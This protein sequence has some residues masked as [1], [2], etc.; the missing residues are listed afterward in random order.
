V[1]HKGSARVSLSTGNGNEL[2]CFPD[3]STTW[4]IEPR[5]HAYVIGNVANA[6]AIHLTQRHRRVLALARDN[7]QNQRWVLQRV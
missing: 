3:G 5:G 7:S 2:V 4:T 1:G 6:T